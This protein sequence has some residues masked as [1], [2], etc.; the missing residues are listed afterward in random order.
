MLRTLLMFPKSSLGEFLRLW[1]L[2]I[3]YFIINKLSDYLKK[4]LMKSIKY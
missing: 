3:I 4:Q 1:V 2:I